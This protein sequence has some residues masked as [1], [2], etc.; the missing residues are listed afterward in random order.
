MCCYFSAIRNVFLRGAEKPIHVNFP[1]L[2]PLQSFY[3]ILFPLELIYKSESKRR[4]SEQGCFDIFPAEQMNNVQFHAFD[5]PIIED[6][7][8]GSGNYRSDSA[9]SS[10]NY[11]Q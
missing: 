2:F 1:N 4:A 10:P 6:G 8:Q 5:K 3:T 7:L 9:K 11:R